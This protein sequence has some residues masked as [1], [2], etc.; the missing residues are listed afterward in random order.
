MTGDKRSDQQDSEHGDDQESFF[1][2]QDRHRL[3]IQGQDLS[4]GWY[5][6]LDPDS[7]R[8]GVIRLAAPTRV[9]LRKQFEMSWF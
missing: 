7:E 2:G 9:L 1:L 6:R 5:P 4:V 8:S 3:S